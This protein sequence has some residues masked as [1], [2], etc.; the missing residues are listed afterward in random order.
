M[1]W[2]SL[3][4]ATL[5]A[6]VPEALATRAAAFWLW[7]ELAQLR[8]PLL[9][10]FAQTA[11]I[12]LGAMLAA[13][14]FLRRAKRPIRGDGIAPLPRQAEPA[15]LGKDVLALQMEDHYV[16]VHRSRGSE[17]VLMSLGRTIECVEAEGLQTH[18][19]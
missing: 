9:L 5:L 2:P 14:F 10:W 11:T 13:S 15:R 12:G 18:R 4:G 3:I 6:S 19:S 16:R 7:P 1:W 17:M 8:L